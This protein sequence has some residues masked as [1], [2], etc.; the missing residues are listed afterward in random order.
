MVDEQM[1]AS[2]GL[3]IY[4]EIGANPGVSSKK[5]MPMEV[6][7]MMLMVIVLKQNILIKLNI[8]HHQT[9]CSYMIRITRRLSMASMH[10]VFRYE[11]I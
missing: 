11:G 2:L 7:L 8:C 3:M 1:Y 10:H 4:D 9:H 6:V 5:L